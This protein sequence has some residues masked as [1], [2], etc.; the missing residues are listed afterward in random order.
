MVAQKTSSKGTKGLAFAAAIH[1]ALI[2]EK[3]QFSRQDIMD[4]MKT[5]DGYHKGSM[6]GSNLSNAINSLTKDGL[7]IESSTHNFS[8][9]PEGEQKAASALG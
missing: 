5:A 7:L 8:L 6:K 2:Q 1:L 3:T 9:T 4:G